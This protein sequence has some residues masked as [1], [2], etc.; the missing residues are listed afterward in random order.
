MPH[1]LN[2]LNSF[3]FLSVIFERFI[4]LSS[5][6]IF[7][8]FIYLKSEVL[9][10]ASRSL[11][12]PDSLFQFIFLIIIFLKE[13]CSE[14]LVCFI[15]CTNVKNKLFYSTYSFPSINTIEI[16]GYWS[17][18]LLLNYSE[19]TSFIITLK[20]NEALTKFVIA[21]EDLLD[22]VK[23]DWQISFIGSAFSCFGVISQQISAS[24]GH[25][26]LTPDSVKIPLIDDFTI[27][28]KG[29]KM[30]AY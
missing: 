11:V 27:W 17:K 6:S 22:F 30:N 20:Y 14:S 3:F 10:M 19:K 9:E 16:R 1:F 25:N 12:C 2:I 28:D 8:L 29:W 18:Y 26:L 4:Q 5:L 23:G 15:C 21:L 7:V 24:E 13:N